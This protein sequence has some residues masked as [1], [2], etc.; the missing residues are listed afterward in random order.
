MI[1]PIEP[2]D[3]P[4]VDGWSCRRACLF[5]ALCVN[6]GQA[7]IMFSEVTSVHMSEVLHSHLYIYVR[8]RGWDS[9]QCP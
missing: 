3:Y 7:S 6:L 1:V 5:W 9:R 4:H 8:V 2:S